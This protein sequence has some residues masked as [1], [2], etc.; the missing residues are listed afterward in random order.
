M[1]ITQDDF[2]A[3]QPGV[4]ELVRA[5][6]AK[7][8]E[9]LRALLGA[10][11]LEENISRASQFAQDQG[12]KPGKYSVQASEGGF[13]VN[14][15]NE[16]SL[17][18]LLGMKDREDDRIERAAT[19][20]GQRIEKAD[21]PGAAGQLKEVK[22]ALPP[23]GQPLRSY[24]PMMNILPNWAV[25][26]GENLGL[27]PEGAR[28]E[29]QAMEAAKAMVRHP[30]YGATLT[31]NEKQSF[32]TAFGAP[33]GGS[34]EDVRNAVRRMENIPIDAM[35]NIESSTR[36][37]AMQRIKERGGM[38]TDELTKMLRG[39]PEQ[40]PAGGSAPLTFEQWK[41]QKRAPKSR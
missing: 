36:P 7:K 24:G 22:D 9:K 30:L 35:R 39:S 14:P 19:V 26:A 17:L 18:A 8:Q 15:E 28:K 41:A 11:A 20:A 6:E 25:S 5:N 12:M 1:A 31:G 32:E 2:Q 29:R 16:Q 13:A 34:E 37:A 4:N 10:Q 21:I 27:I 33:I 3:L 40:A 38:G 23:E